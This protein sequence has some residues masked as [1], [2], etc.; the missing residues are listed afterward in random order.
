MPAVKVRETTGERT[1]ESSAQIRER[2]IPAGR[3][4]RE[5]FKHKPSITCNARVGNRELKQYCPLEEATLE[6]LKF[7]MST[8]Y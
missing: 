5:R 1:G 3:R 7:A 8:E 4:Q 2:V 6:M